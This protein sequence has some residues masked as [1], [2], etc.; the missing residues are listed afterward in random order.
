[1]KISPTSIDADK[2]VKNFDSDITKVEKLESEEY[3]DIEMKSF[4]PM[5]IQKDG[6]NL[7][8]G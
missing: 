8:E 3:D 7:L 5:I 4:A 2:Q 6:R 1:M